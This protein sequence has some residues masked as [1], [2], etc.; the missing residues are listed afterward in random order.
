MISRLL[1]ST[2]GLNNILKYNVSL[3]KS[4][5]RFVRGIKPWRTTSSRRTIGSQVHGSWYSTS[6]S[7]THDTDAIE[8]EHNIYDVSTINH[9]N[10]STQGRNICTKE[11][12]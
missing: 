8:D 1:K 9:M 6:I 4:S 10:Q 7:F 2:E 3:R 12:N 11:R 5:K